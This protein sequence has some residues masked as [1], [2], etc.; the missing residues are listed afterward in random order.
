LTRRRT[1]I[2]SALLGAGSL[3]ALGAKKVFDYSAAA[4]TDKNGDFTFPSGA[5]Q[6]PAAVRATS[7]PPASL[8]FTQRG[9]FTNDAS[10]LNKTAVFGIVQPADEQEIR[11]ALEFARANGLKVSCLGQQHSMGGQSFS[12]E[13]LLLDVQKLNRV[14]LDAKA[15]TVNVQSGARWWQVQRALDAEGFAVKSM[16]SINIFS[17]GGSLSVNG[18]GIDPMPGPIAPTVRSLRVMLCSGE[19]VGASPTENV[20]LFRHVLGGYGLFGVI[21]DAQL[22]VV[23][24]ELYRR[25]ALYMDY[26]DFPAWYRQSV[27][28]SPEIGLAFGRLS[29]APRS[30]LRETAVHLYRRTATPEPL[31]PLEPDRHETLERVVINLSKTGGL[32]R[33]LRWDL[34]KYAEP[35]LH[36]CVSR[37]AAMNL[38]N[39]C[40]VSRNEEMYDDMAYLRNRLPDTDILQEYFV[41]YDH[42][43][44]FTDSLRA[45][46]QRNGTNLL[47]VTIRT[48]HKDTIT[49][50]P[51][52]KADMFGLVLYFNV[53]FNI[54]DNEILRKTTL[55]LIEAANEAEGSFYLPYRLYYSGAQLRR[56]YP[57]V[58]AF[59]AA[60][61]KYDPAGLFSNKWFE[62]YCESDGNVASPKGL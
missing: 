25:E 15:K 46:V 57:E 32:G 40:L 6:E 42:L 54:R 21:L 36:P 28:G 23:E 49:A 20:E 33:S 8:H 16:Q 17:V 7:E 51:Y 50:L 35:H 14:A 41:P 10:H 53:G 18:H 13:G 30:Y 27:E 31:P 24:N 37:N 61:G 59:F 45:I 3:L 11:G 48:V 44:A 12:R 5:G 52:A 4:E 9:G 56:V 55:D 2:G 60:K 1:V 62:K 19:V 29:V 34:E 22:E 58:D 39:E 38:K 43:P 26:K 47:N